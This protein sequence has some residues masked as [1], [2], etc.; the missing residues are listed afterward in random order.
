MLKEGDSVGA[1]ELCS[2]NDQ[3]YVYFHVLMSNLQVVYDN[4]GIDEVRRA[5]SLVP[6]PSPMEYSISKDMENHWKFRDTYPTQPKIADECNRG[7]ESLC[8][9]LLIKQCKEDI[10][11]VLEFLQPRATIEDGLDETE[12]ERIKRKFL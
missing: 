3:M 7:I 9:Y 12:V 5:I 1:K 2:K 4:N 10:P 6:F 11:L 8:N